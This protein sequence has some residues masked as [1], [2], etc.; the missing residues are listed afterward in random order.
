M[1]TQPLEPSSANAETANGAYAYERGKP[2][3][4]SADIKRL[5]HL[6]YPK[7]NDFDVPAF[8][9]R[10]RGLAGQASV[11]H[12]ASE[13]KS[14]FG[15]V[16]PTHVPEGQIKKAVLVYPERA[17]QEQTEPMSADAILDAQRQ[18]IKQGVE[19]K[20]R[21]RATAMF[22]AWRVPKETMSALLHSETATKVES[23]SDLTDILKDRAQRNTKTTDRQNGLSR[24]TLRQDGNDYIIEHVFPGTPVDQLF[25]D[26][27]SK[28]RIAVGTH[29][30]HTL[31]L[32]MVPEDIMYDAIYDHLKKKQLRVK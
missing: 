21:I 14:F 22:D 17:V 6:Q 15:L 32:W 5:Y 18:F 26:V 30:S 4:L 7:P 1:A 8:V 19:Q 13:E 28:D 23:L 9:K 25:Q 24:I 10:L 11:F 16:A 29:D 3:Q 31:L 12:A 2:I 27:P 20:K